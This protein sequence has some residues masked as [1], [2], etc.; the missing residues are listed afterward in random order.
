MADMNR[1]SEQQNPGSSRE[2]SQGMGTN[3]DVQ[4]GRGQQPSKNA[5]NGTDRR[6]GGERR[7]RDGRDGAGIMQMNEGS[8]R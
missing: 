6:T 2:S 3:Q 4:S 7:H 1:N 8:S 5:W